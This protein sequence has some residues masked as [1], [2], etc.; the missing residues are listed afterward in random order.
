MT[1][2]C[3]FAR[4]WNIAGE[5]FPAIDRHPLDDAAAYPRVVLDAA[6]GLGEIGG[7]DDDHRSVK[8]FGAHGIRCRQKPSST[9]LPAIGPPKR[10]KPSS[11]SPFTKVACSGQKGC[12][13]IGFEGSQLGPCSET[14]TKYTAR[15]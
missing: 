9:S 13:R 1:S 3:L 4:C 10:K 11:I 12:S 8:A 7:F 6:Y 5:K 2:R 14:T 15:P